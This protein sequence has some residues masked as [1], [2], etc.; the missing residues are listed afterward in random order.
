MD[1]LS[2]IK[3][4]SVEIIRESELKERILSKHTLRVKAGFDP[5][6]ADIH[7]GHTVLMEKLRHFQLAGHTV[8]FLIGDFTAMI[9]DPTGVSVTRPQLSREQVLRN[10][11]TYTEQAFKILDPVKTEVRYN[12]EWFMKMDMIQL[13]KLT[14]NYTIARLLE[15][16]DFKNRYTENKPIGIHELLYPLMQGYDSVMLNAD[17]EIGGNDQK[18]NLLVGRVLQEAY[19]QKP[20]I[21]L[22]M[23]LLPGLDGIK[24]M[25]KSYGNYIGIDEP[26]DMMFG[27]IMSIS[28]ELMWS[29]YELLTDLPESVIASLKE[30]SLSKKQNPM[31]IKKQLAFMICKRFHS[32][33][34][35][36]EAMHDFERIFS[37][38]ELPGNLK[39][40]EMHTAAESVLLYDLFADTGLV[41]SKSETKRLIQS[42]S[43][44]INN[45]T[46]NDIFYK[47]NAHGNYIIKIG[48]KKPV[49]MKF[50]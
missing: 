12:S 47:L 13:M 31:D 38:K 3:K 2:L 7:L 23:P 46:I 14:S 24:K 18:F 9:G 6:S 19:N 32:E 48:K 28:D 44:S 34:K 27:K 11:K 8:L 30:Q 21:V 33:E 42:G 41:S 39:E 36:N 4:G 22:T 26:A 5:T 35:A 45:E 43:I 20:Q 50:L 15:R 10:A 29:Y 17:V 49:K 40:Y 37:R 16:D 25:S 1:T